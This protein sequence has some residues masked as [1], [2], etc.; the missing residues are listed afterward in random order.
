VNRSSER[1]RADRTFPAVPEALV[2]IRDYV[3]G[4]AGDADLPERVTEDLVLAVSEASANA[5]IHSGSA[6]VRIRWLLRDDRVEVNV[7]DDGVFRSRVRVPSVDRPGGF[8]IPLMA[9]LSDE[10]SIVEGTRRRPGTSVRLVKRSRQ[11]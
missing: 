5:V 1:A 3:R 6:T 9:A 8:G 2:D 11:D 7:V 10:V 4:L